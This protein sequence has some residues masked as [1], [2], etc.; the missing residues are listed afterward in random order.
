MQTS[1]KFYSTQGPKLAADSL[2]CHENFWQSILYINL[3]LTFELGGYKKD[4]HSKM[5]KKLT[6]WKLHELL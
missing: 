1:P 4:L 2:K 6:N 3:Q 5:G